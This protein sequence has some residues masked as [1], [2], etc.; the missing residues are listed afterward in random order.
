ML[1][2][3]PPPTSP[4]AWS[5]CNSAS[6][7]NRPGRLRPFVN[8]RAP[9]VNANCNARGR[10]LMD[11]SVAFTHDAHIPPPNVRN[12]FGARSTKRCSPTH[13]RRPSKNL[14][15]DLLRTPRLRRNWL[16]G[17]T[18]PHLSAA[19]RPTS[20]LCARR[21]QRQVLRAGS[22]SH[23]PRRR[24]HDD[25][26]DPRGDSG[27]LHAFRERPLVAARTRHADLHPSHPIGRAALFA[28][29]RTRRRAELIAHPRPPARAERC[30]GAALTAAQTPPDK[31]TTLQPR[32]RSPRARRR[33]CAAAGVSRRP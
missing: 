17:S 15:G 4:H 30:A 21:I 3:R 6:V 13:D 2:A 32:A 19:P 1:R 5:A 18:L 27:F 10:G 8:G 33:F 12:D 16:Q 9:L 20:R 23:F 7:S 14:P 11:A 28:R 26:I 29:I 31:A 25:R 22:R 24:G